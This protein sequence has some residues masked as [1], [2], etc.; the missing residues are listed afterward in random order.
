MFYF[1]RTGPTILSTPVWKFLL[2]SIKLVVIKSCSKKWKKMSFETSLKLQIS[3]SV[4]GSLNARNVTS[5]Y[6]IFSFMNLF[7][8]KE[9]RDTF[10]LCIY[11]LVVK[12][13]ILVGNTN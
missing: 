12:V 4:Q 3:I 5:Y 10:M 8:C 7:C 13:V 1:G 9:T 11:L 6:Y 2:L